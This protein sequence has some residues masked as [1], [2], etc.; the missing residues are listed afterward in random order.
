M[1]MV[2]NRKLDCV[3]C[4]FEIDANTTR[5]CPSCG[6]PI[7]GAKQDGNKKRGIKEWLSHPLVLLVVGA[8]ITSFLLPQLTASWQVNEKE[9]DLKYGLAVKGASESTGNPHTCE[10]QTGDP[11]DDEDNPDSGNPHNTGDEDD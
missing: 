3:K 1:G 5:Y 2:S 9:L 7:E 10:Q 11:H 4:G 6:S 8:A